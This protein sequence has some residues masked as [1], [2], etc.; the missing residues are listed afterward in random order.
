MF[1]GF[2]LVFPKLM[3]KLTVG[4]VKLGAKLK[5]VKDV[6]KTTVRATKVVTDFKTAFKVMATSPVKLIL[7]VLVCLAHAVLIFAMP[8]FVMRVFVQ[9][10]SVSVLTVMA[11]NA[12]TIFGVSFIPTPGNTGVMEWLSGLAFSAVAGSTLAWSV[13]TWRLSVFYLFIFVGIG[14]TIFD[15]IVKNVKAKR[16]R[17]LLTK[18]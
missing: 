8:Y 12:Y 14:I 11:L 3:Q 5:I 18:K 6:E 1:V 15:I 13:L 9:D 7:L 2:F 17:K 16:E 4:V 10:I